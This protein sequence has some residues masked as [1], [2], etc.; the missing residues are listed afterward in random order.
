MQVVT[1][2]TTLVIRAPEPHELAEAGAVT[3]AAYRAAGLA[4]GG[5]AEVL[6]D[7]GR[8]DAEAELLVAVEGGGAVLGSVTFCPAGS[9]W[10]ELALDDEGELRMLAVRPEAQRLGV[11]RALTRACITRARELGFRALVLSTPSGASA[12]HR[13]YESLGFLR[14]RAR[15]WSPVPGVDLLAYVLPMD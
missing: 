7:A 1:R 8:R 11:G 9:P 4:G 12:P 3:E 15:D 13:L 5:Y 6:R 14:D 10:R 2:P